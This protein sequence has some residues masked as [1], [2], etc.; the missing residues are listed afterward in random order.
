MAHSILQIFDLL[1]DGRYILTTIHCESSY[2][3]FP[4]WKH[5]NLANFNDS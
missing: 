5:A 4:G 1:L 3:T 2:A